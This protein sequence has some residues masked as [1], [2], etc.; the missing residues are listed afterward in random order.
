MGVHQDLR[1]T[2]EKIA[3]MLADEWTFDEIADRL[4]LTVGQVRNRYLAFCAKLGVKPDA[5]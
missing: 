3:D 2:D 4:W 5:E 1:T